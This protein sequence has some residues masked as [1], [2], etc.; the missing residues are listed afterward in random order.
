MN[1][2]KRIDISVI[3]PIYN[4]ADYL[5]QCLDSIINQTLKT[6]EIICV[7]NGSDDHSETILKK[8]KRI[9]P[10][11]IIITTPKTNA[12]NARN[13]GIKV[14]KGEYLSFVDADD[15][16]EPNML[17]TAL[18]SAQK[19]NSDMVV[20]EFRTYNHQTKT[21]SGH[22]MGISY[23]GNKNNLKPTDIKDS[24]F[25][26]FKNCPWNKLFRR[27]FILDNNISF[28]EIPRANDICFTFI[29]LA[30]AKR[31][32]LVKKPLINYRFNTRKSLQS[33]NNLSPL[34]SWDAYRFTKAKLQSLDL[35]SIYEQSFLN[36]VLENLL[37]NLNS[38]PKDTIAYYYLFNAIRYGSDI[39][40]G[41]TKHNPNYYNKEHY[42]NYMEILN[43]PSTSELIEQA[44]LTITSSKS[45]KIGSAITKIPRLIKTKLPTKNPTNN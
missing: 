23:K 14:A 4:S 36:E 24:L 26:S 25:N 11:I 18:L 17:E 10:R 9:D 33:T 31:I 32:T 44:T 20:F 39:E 8:Y 7:D 41:I 35:Y 13:Q 3:I 37:Y 12:G 40:F 16:C 15:F 38:I 6:I 45:Y 30:L 28:Q 42:S 5:E 43:Y 29:S 1:M 27:R 2:N 19:N 21:I 22:T 34:S